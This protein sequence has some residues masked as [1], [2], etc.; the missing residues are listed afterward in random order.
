M[1]P[2][3]SVPPP[4]SPYL[5]PPGPNPAHTT[6]LATLNLSLHR[7]EA[8]KAAAL[9]AAAECDKRAKANAAAVRELT[10][11]LQAAK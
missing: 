10:A 7:C 2:T 1:C 8:E 5:P 6:Q 4:A 3:G 9:A 11:Q